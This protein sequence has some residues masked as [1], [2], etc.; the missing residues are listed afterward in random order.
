[1]RK[2][3]RAFKM[4]LPA[5]LALSILSLLSASILAGGGMMQGQ[6]APGKSIRAGA[7]GMD[8]PGFT[9]GTSIQAPV[10]LGSAG[11]FVIL[12]KSGIST[13]GT[14]S[15]VGNIGVSP[16]AAS[17]ITG[18]DLIMDSSNQFATSSLVTGNVYAADYAPPT[19]TV[20]TTAISDMETAYTDAAGRTLPDYTELGAGNIGG[21]TLVPGLYKWSSGVTIPTDVTLSGSSNDVWIFQ[22]AQNL[23]ISSATQVI[24]S[25]DAQANNIFWQVAGQTTLGTTSVFYGNILDQTA[26][27]LNT[28][29]TLNGRALAQTVVTCDAN[30]ITMP[31]DITAPTVTLT[32]PANAAT[33]VAVNSAMAA[34]FSEAMD[35]LTIT[36]STF[37]L[38][39]GVT[40]VSGT[41]TY[42]GLTA[43]FTPAVDL[44][45]NTVYNA[46]ITT[47]AKDL[48]GNALASDYV[49]SFTTGAA[50]DIIAPTVTLTVPA[51]AATGVAING[52]M[53]ATFSEAM[54]PLTITTATFILKQGATPVSGAVTYAGVTATFTPAVDLAY[55]T[56][57]N[58]TITTGAMDLAG[59]AL[60][61]NYTWTFTT[62]AA[63]AS[64][65]LPL[66]A[67]IL[68]IVVVAGIVAAAIFRLAKKPS[69]K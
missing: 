45:Y 33:G 36:S 28:G 15:I 68:I 9:T 40:P 11:N 18:F 58:A 10:D 64:S 25:D 41:V 38:V 43:T 47:G 23:D 50:P 37:T 21:M 57:Y 6:S 44:A 1:M 39:H 2:G 5:L 63:P 62:G 17:Y 24:L 59:N 65:G 7:G 49:W 52:A 14:T 66:W 42:S 3:A 30:A 22:I 55:N 34:S 31:K 35:N 53:T 8:G 26:I 69:K 12:A 51:N 19:P 13:T 29:A 16:A 48:A 20:M 60:A 46:T 27:V 67:I 61:S 32:V 4:I 56:V 54:D